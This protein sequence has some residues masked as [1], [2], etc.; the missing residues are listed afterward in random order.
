M[1]AESASKEKPLQALFPICVIMA[2]IIIANVN[3]NEEYKYQKGA[4]HVE[5]KTDLGTL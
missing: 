5:F 1:T 3:V 4:V 2:P